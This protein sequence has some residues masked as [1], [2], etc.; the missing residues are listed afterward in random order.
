MLG[1]LITEYNDALFD[2]DKARAIRVVEEAV[3]QGVTP[4][5]V[6]F[7][8]AVPAMEA[9]M[10]FAGRDP[11]ANLARHY[12][13]AQIAAEVTDR[14]VARFQRPPTTVGRVILGNSRGDV[15]SLGKRIVGACLRAL[16]LEVI[17]LG[18]NVPPERFVD[19]AV[20]RDAQVIAISSMMVHTAKGPNGCLG[21][22]RI[23]EERKLEGRL[24]LAVGGAPY[25]FDAEL[26]RAV[27]ADG[28]AR[29][30]IGAG[31]VILALI[32]EVKS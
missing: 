12:M 1:R 25:R 30:G 17:D 21:V 13:T 4:E 31:K 22:R 5:T 9:A 2:T 3:A 7:D 27:G 16:M 10:D 19:E 14:M 24:R 29:D 28:W 18:A 26:H 8:V 23:L 6:V 32:E 15:H 20:A 11:D